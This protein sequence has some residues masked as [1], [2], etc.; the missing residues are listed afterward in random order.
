MSEFISYHNEYFK[1]RSLVRISSIN[2]IKRDLEKGN[3][4]IWLN[5]DDEPITIEGSE[6]ERV[7]GLLSEDSTNQKQK[8]NAQIELESL[9]DFVLSVG[10]F[11]S[12]MHFH[13]KDND[14]LK[15][16]AKEL[17]HSA[18]E[19]GYKLARLTGETE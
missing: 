14:E 10:Y 8:S 18:A 5:G 2:F 7:W 3:V 19:L 11:A 1:T 17:S 13:V 12:T 9:R 4:V 16:A 6:A 15:L